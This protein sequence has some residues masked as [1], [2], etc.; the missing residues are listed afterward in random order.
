MA[1]RGRRGLAVGLA[2]AVLLGVVGTLAAVPGTS[3][4]SRTRTFPPAGPAVQP[5]RTT[6]GE[7]VVQIVAHPDDDLFFMNPDTAQSLATGRSLT[8]VYLTAGESDGVNARRDEPDPPAADKAAYAEARQNGI[9]AAYAE[10]ATGDRTSP[11]SRT[12]V[13]TAGGGTAELDTLRAKPWISL[14][15]VQLH[16]AGSI[17]GDRPHSLHGLWDGRV[18][19]LSS[20]LSS[21][22]PVRKDFAYTKRQVVETVAGLLGRFRP[23]SV[24]IQ[25]PTPGRTPKGTYTDHQDHM[26]GA[27]FAQAALARYAAAPGHPAFGVQTYL[28]YSTGAL[29]RTLSPADAEAKLRTLKTYAWADGTDHCGAPA[30]CGDRKVAARPAGHGWAQTVRHTRGE[31]TTWTQP[32]PGGSA[33]AF[34]VLDQ[35]LAVWHRAGATAGWTG[36]RLLGGGGIDTGVTSVRLPDGRMAVLGTRTT[37]G[38]RAA[39]YRRDVVLRVQRARGGDFGPWTSLGTPERDDASGTSAVSAPAAVVDPSGRLTVF[40]RDSAH[41]L[42][43]RAGLPDGAWGPWTPLGGS[44]LRGDPVAATD[45]SGRHTVLVPTPSSVLAWAQGEPGGPL[46]G[47]LRTGLPATTLALNA[48]ADARGDGIRLWYRT[49]VTGEVRGAHFRG[50]GAG[51]G[52][53]AGV[54]GTGER[55][56]AGGTTPGSPHAGTAGTGTAAGA[57]MGKRAGSGPVP[58]AVP[59][60][61]AMLAPVAS[62]VP[63]T[64]VAGF[65]PVGRSGDLLAVR[66]RAGVLAT[67]RTRERSRPVPGTD[68]AARAGWTEGRFLLAGAPAGLPGGIAAIGLDGTLHWTPSDRTGTAALGSR[69]E[70]PE[71]LRR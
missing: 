42:T 14:V 24:R 52:A 4:D 15:W 36:P 65:G 33:W 50:A 21:G 56:V 12:A 26:Y 67:T 66:S 10:M 37:L 47:P 9:R 58:T 17:N 35:R 53:G 44:G 13:P 32:G 46:S 11:W 29:P 55:G 40:V 59:V 22:T 63:S 70:G 25:D 39:D 1:H 20:Q 34:S 16:E 19:T 61:A 23:T 57:G 49:P 27:R 38:G 41:R 18:D 6:A 43:G 5:V 7:R 31:S 68:L 28:G 51:T 69:P 30:G 8:S 45:A 3:A 60:K 2:A 64:G 62:F 71:S 48:T 54:P